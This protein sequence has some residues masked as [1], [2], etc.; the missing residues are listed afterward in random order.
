MRAYPE[1]AAAIDR[2]VLEYGK[3]FDVGLVVKFGGSLKT[4]LAAV[5]CQQ[6]RYENMVGYMGENLLPDY[7]RKAYA[8][9]SFLAK[10]IQPM[11]FTG[12]S[13][14]SSPLV[15]GFNP[16]NQVRFSA[17]LSNLSN[18]LCRVGVVRPRRLRM[19]KLEMVNSLPIL[20]TESLLRPVGEK[21]GLFA[22]SKKSVFPNS[23]VTA[24]EMKVIMTSSAWGLA[25]T[26]SAGQLWS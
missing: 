19:R 23:L 8:L 9:A 17:F 13:S 4:L 24:E 1:F 2:L 22:V 7:S 25:E 15:G 18:S 11:D 14:G 16:E 12:I 20:N 26:I 5:I 3:G 10:Q 6:V 21:F